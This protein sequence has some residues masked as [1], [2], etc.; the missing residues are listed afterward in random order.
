MISN[1]KKINNFYYY[2]LIMSF[3]LILLIIVVGGLTRLTNSGLS[4]TEWELI[5]GILP[6]L[7]E[8]SWQKYFDLYKEI[9][10]FKFLNPLMDL[11]EFKVIFYWEYFHRILARLIGL[12]FLIPLIYFHFNKKINNKYLKPCYLIF[13]LIL[14]QGLVG[15]YMV[16]SGLVNNV[17]VSHYRL[18]LHLGIAI[19]IICILYW[20]ILIN[21]QV[22]NKKFFSISKERF[23]FLILIFLIF[24]QILLG[25]FVSGLDAGSIYQTWPL[26]GNT[27]VPNDLNLEKVSHFLNFDNHSL[28]Q[29]YHR[30]FA[31]FIFFYICIL[32]LY[33]YK[34]E[35]EKIYKP[36]AFLLFILFIQVSLGIYTLLSN[37]NIHIAS[38]HQIT[39][40]I[41]ILSAI[42]LYYS[43]IK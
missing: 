28:I 40:V 2:W 10:Q 12:V 33:I 24:L 16:I 17:T 32:S 30:N 37:L 42:N 19:S 26:M 23:P 29:F 34:N 25:A 35:K 14:F 9:P 1:D 18:S 41:L 8:T 39:S 3:S 22:E 38:L 36:L 15:W 27:Y 5:T 7:N 20:Q 6:P 11:E 21:K 4:I 31:Y 13:I 43:K